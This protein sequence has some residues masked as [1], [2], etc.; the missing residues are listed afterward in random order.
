MTRHKG[1]ITRP[2]LQ[3]NWPHHGALPTWLTHRRIHATVSHPDAARGGHLVLR[4][5]DYIVFLSAVL[6]G[7]FFITLWLTE[8]Q[9]PNAAD[10]RS[11]AELLAA[12]SISDDS[13]L[14]QSAHEAGLIMSQRLFGHGDVIR[15]IDEQKVKLLGW[16]ADGQ[17]TALEVLVFVAGHLVAMT[18]TAGERPDV[19]AA[20]QLGFGANKNLA[21]SA[22]FTCRKG[23]QPVVVVLGKERD[24][25]DLQPSRCP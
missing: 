24:Y 13:D 16:A 18:H 9:V 12:Y 11:P 10:N 8:P 4:R 21:F 22:N 23:D 6:F 25:L 14:A 7:S 2:G 20:L 5:A 1:E 19:T 15:R 3:R 17:G